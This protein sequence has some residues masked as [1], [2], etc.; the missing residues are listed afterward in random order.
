MQIVV[1]QIPHRYR[2]RFLNNSGSVTVNKNSA[3]NSAASN[4]FY[5]VNIW[6]QYFD[7]T[8]DIKGDFV[9]EANVSIGGKLYVNS[10]VNIND[11]VEIGH[12]ASVGGDL[13]CN[14]SAN[15]NGRLSVGGLLLTHN[16]EPSTPTAYNIGSDSSRYGSIYAVRN[17]VNYVYVGNDISAGNIYPKTTATYNLGSASL[18]YLNFYGV[19]TNSVNVIATNVTV[20]SVLTAPVIS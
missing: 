13:Y 15:I 3:S 7:D 18:K 8:D 5:P 6:G 11:Y 9:S 20:D 19:N 1:S 16:M 10:S 4:S 14:S 2:N 17:Y 12:N